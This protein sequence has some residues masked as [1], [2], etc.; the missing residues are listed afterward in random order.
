MEKNA[1]CKVAGFGSVK[2]K[3]YDNFRQCVT[4]SYSQEESDLFGHS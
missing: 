1:A 4:C 2:V 3:I